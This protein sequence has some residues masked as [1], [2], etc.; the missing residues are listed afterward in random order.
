MIREKEIVESF[1]KS[2]KAINHFEQLLKLVRSNNDT[3]RLGLNNIEE[4]ESSK[5]IEERSDKGKNTKLT[6]YLCSKKGHT[7]NYVG[8]RMPITRKYSI[9][10]VTITNAISKDT[11]HKI[12][13]PKL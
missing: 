2:S 9:T 8:V 3:S 4:G 10:R 7:S 1:K 11:R 13:G 12:V 6:C 5:S